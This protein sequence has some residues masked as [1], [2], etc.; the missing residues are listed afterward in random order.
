M[1]STNASIRSRTVRAVAV[2]TSMLLV[3]AGALGFPA[4][5]NAAGDAVVTPSI[6]SA[7]PDGLTLRVDFTGVVL[8]PDK[9]GVYVA[10]TPHGIVEPLGDGQWVMPAQMPGGTGSGSYAVPASALDRT[11]DY[12]ALVWYAHGNP[13]PDA[14]VAQV[15]VE[16]TEGQWDAIFPPI[17]TEP[18]AT[19][20]SLQSSVPTAE[21][22]DA[23][24]FTA[25]VAPIAPGSVTFVSGSTKLGSATVD[26][27]GTAT[28]RTTSLDAGVHR[29]TAEFVPA[30]PA[31]FAPSTS[32]AVQVTVTVPEEPTGPS[33]TGS[34]QWGI[35]SSFVNYIENL[36]GDGVV[37]LTPPTTRVGSAFAFPQSAATTWDAERQTGTVQFAG[38]AS[39]S[40]H[41][42]ALAFAIANPKIVVSSASAAEL[43]V[44]TGGRDVVLAMLDL[45]KATK[46]SLP[47][48]SVRWA[49]VPAILTEAGVPVFQQYP[50]GQDLD[51]LTFTVGASADIEPVDPPVVKPPSKPKPEQEQPNATKPS[52]SRTAGSLVWGISSGFAAYTTGNIAKGSVSTSGVGRSGGSYVFPQAT[53]GDWNAKS[54]T[55][56]V[57]YSGVVTFTGH[58]GLLTETFANPVISISSG[59]TGAISAGGRTFTL[60]LAD[61]EKSTAADGSVT[62]RNVPVAGAITGGGASGGAAGGGS[63]GI[64]PVT[65]T[66]GAAAPNVYGSTSTGHPSLTNQPDPTP[67]ATTGITLVTP[68][69]QLVAGGEIEFSAPGFT[70][71]ERDILVVLYS[72]PIVLD[73]NAGAGSDGVVRWI[74]TLPENLTGTHTL[75]VQGSTDAGQVID[76][77]SQEEYDALQ[78]SAAPESAAAPSAAEVRA[79][80]PVPAADASS[81]AL[82]IGAGA[83]IIVAIGMSALVVMQRRR[84]TAGSAV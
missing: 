36:S 57:R 8:P 83:L 40:A 20:L 70:P 63:F 51:P 17:V 38:A 12:D 1:I 27:S 69:D 77:L 28:L 11:K 55:G 9:A 68:T 82:W 43:I 22:A 80:G 29:I 60:R 84:Q 31:I 24:T 62:W 59:S 32:S 18:A 54:A 6:T 67:P 76:I 25:R 53:G 13:S 65:F 49:D 50:A 47:D 2:I 14:I 34:L 21:V 58:H 5:A 79:A 75:T 64:D 71:G 73:R 52:S 16:I 72:E 45:S 33:A 4:A 66:V 7:T 23:V 30:N 42:G 26:S 74:G 46:T 3:M 81:S 19:T 37:S 35:K 10:L 39:F 61:A 56:T 48:G 41:G 44:T 15:P 78:R